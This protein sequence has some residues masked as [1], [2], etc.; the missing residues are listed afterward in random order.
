MK[1]SK[2]K[3]APLYLTPILGLAGCTLP[4]SHL[5]HDDAMLREAMKGVNNVPG[6]MMGGSSAT[7]VAP[8]APQVRNRQQILRGR[9]NFIGSVP[10]AESRTGAAGDIVFNFSHQPIE[11]V[12]NTIL[13]DILK[14]NY[15]ISPGVTGDVSFSTSHPVTKEEALSILETL[16]SWN[17]NA[18]IK[19]GEQ[20]IVLPAS[21]AIAGQ[22][23]PRLPI[24]APVE[25]LSVRLFSLKY[26]SATEM[27]KLLKPYA[28]ENSF[29]Q[30][31]NARNIIAMAGSSD[32]LDNY[33]RTIDTFDVNWLKG[34]SVGVYALEHASVKELMPQL[35]EVFGDNSS[36]PL[37]GMVKF[38]PVERTNSVVAIS[39]QSEYLND[40]GNWIRTI[41]DGGGNEP[42]LYVYDVL[43]MKAQELAH[44]LAEI[45]GDSRSDTVGSSAEVA[46]GLTPKTLSSLA[47]NESEN[48]P[49]P[50]SAITANEPSNLA[51]QEGDGGD[52]FSELSDD[53]S[54]ADAVVGQLNNGIRITAQK[55]S[56][57]LLV[58]ARPSQW[59]EIESAIHRLDRVPQQVQIETRILEVSLSGELEQGVQWYLGRLAGSDNASDV[60]N[61][62]GSQSALGGGG[63][64]LGASDALFYSFVGRRL[65]VA[66]RALETSSRTQVLSAPSLVVMNNQKA[67]IQVGDDIP[68]SQTS[69]NTN[70]STNTISSVEYLQT[71]VILD[72][73]PRVN[74]D[75]RVYMDI[76]QQVSDADMVNAVND[77]PKI[78][79]RSVN[80]KIAVQS[81]QTVLLGGLIKQNNIQ[82]ESAVPWLGRIPGLGWLFSSKS[83]GR[84]RTEL[85]VLITPRVISDSNQARLITN[86]YREQ[87]QLLKPGVER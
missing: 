13:G 44:Y 34:M 37:A 70:N 48:N 7:G 8:N 63:M 43:N 25:G 51:G 47:S 69:I 65:Q 84:S 38:M 18:L 22:L 16:L 26:I 52:E 33:Q 59:Q 77:N 9:G 12:V 64:G 40:I 27:Q 54:G 2:S 60:A 19:Q 72:V 20:Y 62:R 86:D 57:Q 67:K 15:T 73:L 32:E 11:A 30:T 76:R 14:V 1:I 24:S 71:G 82:S 49:E 3:L 6:S 36:S 35:K 55:S 83:R 28:P 80:T 66:L 81:G 45:Y 41:D 10:P 74:P 75:G 58:R 56:N 61:T 31:D 21:K 78:S 39:P 42:V 53:E 87:M 5:Q 4:D 79:T 46:P 68:V 17:N 29:L 85:I 50:G 23:I